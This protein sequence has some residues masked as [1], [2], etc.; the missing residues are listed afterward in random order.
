MPL[1]I[2]TVPCL[3]D[4]YAFLAHDAASGETALVDVP[5]AA[6][7]L[8]ALSEKGWT[9]SHILITHHHA[10]HVQGLDEVL[11]AH[12]DAKVVGHAADADRLPKLDMALA[13]GDTV[14][15]GGST[16][17]VMDVSGHTVGH[18]AY[19]FPDSNA[20]FTADSLMALGCGRVFEGT[21]PM[22]WASLSK[23]AALPDDTVVYSGHEYTQ[24]NG[25]F[26]LSVDPD[27]PDL[28]A[29][30]AD[31]AAA[32]DKGEP[33]VPSALALEKATNPFLRAPALAEQLGM[34]GADPAEVFGEIRRRKDSF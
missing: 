30:V 20:A 22:M 23:L 33:T 6:P 34:A 25:R 5:E 12:P 10:D 29:R 31:I 16:G 19:H 11:S 1:K 2:V 8:A 17:T 18:I 4:N 7:I 14:T 21:M 9:L 26:A 15:V 32:R 3:S 27:N 13:E 24:A 28:Q